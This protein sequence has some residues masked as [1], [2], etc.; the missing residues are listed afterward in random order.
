MIKPT[1]ESD[2][3]KVKLWL[4]D[5][6]PVIKQLPITNLSLITDPPYP[7]WY[8]DEYQFGETTNIVL[9]APWHTLLSFWTPGCNFPAPFDSCHAWDKV[10]GTHTQF[11]LI[12]I[13][14]IKQGHLLLRYMT[15]HSS[16]RA[17]I[18]G[19]KNEAHKSQKPIRLMCDL[20]KDIP[21]DIVDPFMGSGTTGVAA[22][23]HERTFY[24]MEID[25]DYFQLSVRRIKEALKSDPIL[26]IAKRKKLT[27]PLLKDAKKRTF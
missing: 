21:G 12:Y 24:G 9:S 10:V 1:W 22:V 5:C 4:G 19:D 3:G 13:R 18:C 7:T 25:P 27:P 6:L 2:C 11:E 16:V 20:V 23:K 8:Q 15:P 14:G 17:K 26:K